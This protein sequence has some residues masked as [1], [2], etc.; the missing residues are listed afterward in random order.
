MKL[1]YDKCKHCKYFHQH[2]NID[3]NWIYKVGC[4][5]CT[6]QP[7]PNRFGYYSGKQPCPYFEQ[8]KGQKTRIKKQ[9][10]VDLL[11]NLNCNIEFIKLFL[12]KNN[13]QEISD[14]MIDK[15]NK[16]N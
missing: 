6:K 16:L 10:I 4:G 2:Y 15:L 8:N 11:E 13:K 14:I 12:N 1:D 5:N 9:L 3:F 7:N